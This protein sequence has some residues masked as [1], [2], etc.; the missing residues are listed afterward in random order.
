MLWNDLALVM[1][2]LTADLLHTTESSIMISNYKRELSSASGWNRRSAAADVTS[3][4][5]REHKTTDRHVYDQIYVDEKLSWFKA[6]D[7][8]ERKYIRV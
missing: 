1:S 3:L 7:P 2:D 4:L 8:C 6:S 5:E